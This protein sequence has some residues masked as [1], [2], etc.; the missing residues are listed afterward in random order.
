MPKQKSK[1]EHPKKEQSS[2]KEAKKEQVPKKTMVKEATKVPKSPKAEP[3][4]RDHVARRWKK[5]DTLEA[6]MT[7][8]N[9]YKDTFHPV[10]VVE[11]LG[12]DKYKCRLT[13]FNAA[14]DI[15]LESQ[16][17]EPRPAAPKENYAVGDEVH[18]LWANRK[19]DGKEVDGLMKDKGVWVKG[20][21]TS[22]E[23][24]NKVSV[25]YNNCEAEE[26]RKMEIRTVPL[27]LLRTAE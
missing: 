5:G 8:E 21:I 1:K 25:L 6:E 2:K 13:A 18:F 26:K 14:S 3:S 15:W 19:V 10:V 22:V 11:V 12:N 7:D 9:P 20:T 17:H 24:R 27:K 16:L 4:K 23:G